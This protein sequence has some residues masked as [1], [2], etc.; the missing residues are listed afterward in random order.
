MAI[1][2]TVAEV[3]TN[4][5]PSNWRASTG[6]TP[7]S[8]SPGSSAKR[9]SP[10]SCPSTGAIASPPSP[11]WKDLVHR[12][13]CFALERAIPVI[14]FEKDQRKEDAPACSS[15]A[16]SRPSTWTARKAA[17]SGT[18]MKVRLCGPKPRSMT[19]VLPSKAS[20]TSSPMP[21]SLPEIGLKV[22]TFQKT[23]TPVGDPPIAKVIT[24]ANEPRVEL[25][26]NGLIQGEE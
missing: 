2:R 24:H 5:S 10:T 18:T 1:P 17:S 23:R 13:E 14:T 22:I 6:C 4:T 16:S 9:A 26:E 20:P 12:L 19:R 3:S 8:T 25:V 11:A 7:T 15:A 21:K